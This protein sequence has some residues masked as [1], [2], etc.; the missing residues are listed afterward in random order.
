ME[1][2]DQEQGGQTKS[3]EKRPAPRGVNIFAGV[4]L[5]VCGLVWLGSNYN[6]L[7]PQVINTLFSWQMLLVVIGAWM[8]CTKNYIMGGAVTLLGVVLVVVDYFHI[9]ISFER[10]VLPLL[11]VIAGVAL[12]FIKAPKQ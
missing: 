5:I 7:G 3:T 11:V 6:I 4:V 9:Y 12:L 1:V 8:L 10:F 2:L